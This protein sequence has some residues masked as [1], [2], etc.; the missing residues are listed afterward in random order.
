M[1]RALSF[2]VSENLNDFIKI[3]NASYFIESNT[4]MLFI[5][6]SQINTEFVELR[7]DIVC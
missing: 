6:A 1:R 2:K 7:Y 4:N 3:N 5:D